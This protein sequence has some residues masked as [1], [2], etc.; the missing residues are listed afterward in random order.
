MKSLKE[1]LERIQIAWNEDQHYKLVFEW[2]K[3]GVLSLSEFRE[4]L[5]LISQLDE[6]ESRKLWG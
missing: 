5:D 1:K 3:T 6:D 2:V 4:A